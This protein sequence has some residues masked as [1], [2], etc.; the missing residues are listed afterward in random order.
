[1]SEEASWPRP[2]NSID[3]GLQHERTALAWERTAIAMMVAGLA[4]DRYAA[5]E[6]GL[7]LGSVGI[8]Q[9]AAGA[10][11]L[12]WASRNDKLLHDPSRPASAIPQVWLTRVVGMGNLIFVGLAFTVVLVVSVVK[13]F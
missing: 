5:K 1:M 3:G 8:V 2:V 10:M 7:L 11:L 12:L 4:L 13:L 9:T 6:H